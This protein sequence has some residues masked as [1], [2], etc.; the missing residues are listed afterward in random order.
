[1]KEFI[2]DTAERAIK[3]ICQTAVA[4][5]GA[6]AMIGEVNWL[7]VL[8]TSALA[9]IVSVLTSIGSYNIGDTGTASLIKKG[10]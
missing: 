6:T 9:G 10:E 7:A 3:T 2:K 4:T 8:S 1:M 5:I